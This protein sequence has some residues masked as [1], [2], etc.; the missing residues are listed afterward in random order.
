MD[1]APVH[2]K[3]VGQDSICKIGES[4]FPKGVDTSLRQRK[5]DGLGKVQG[6]GVGVSEV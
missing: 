6:R 2:G 1:H 5:I 3:C 4:G